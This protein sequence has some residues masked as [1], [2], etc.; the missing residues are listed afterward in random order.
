[1]DGHNFVGK[2]SNDTAD[3][4]DFPIPMRKKKQKEETGRCCWPSERH[5]EPT[6]PYQLTEI[7]NRLIKQRGT[8]RRL[9]LSNDEIDGR[10][11]NVTY[12]YSERN[13]RN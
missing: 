8:A 12:R 3:G 4:N 1:M 10:R 7:E 9:L 5:G 2:I 6:R 11:G 13:D